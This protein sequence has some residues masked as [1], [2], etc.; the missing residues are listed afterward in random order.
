MAEETR[1]PLE[2]ANGG[3][4]GDDAPLLFRISRIPSGL[5]RS[6]RVRAKQAI[7][8]EVPNR[9]RHAFRIDLTQ[10]LLAGL[11]TGAVFPFVGVIARD[12]L[13]ATPTVL[14]LIGAAPFI[15]NLLAM[16]FAQAS[17]GRPKAPFVSWAQIISRLIILLSLFA[18]GA[19]PFALVIAGCQI[20]GT[21]ATPAY[22]AVIKDVYP[23]DQRGK[24]LGFTKASVLAAQCAGTLLAG[25]LMGGAFFFKV[26]YTHLFPI[27]GA[28]GVIAAITFGRINPHEAEQYD[29]SAPRDPV[30]KQIKAT[31]TFV[32]KTLSI[33]KED[34]AYRWFALSVFT[35][36]FGNL[37][38]VPLIP[39]IQVDELHTTS[40]QIALLSNM[41]QAAAV[42]GYFFWGRYVDR[43]SP[44]KAVIINVLLNTLIPLVYI[45]TAFMHGANAWILTPAF[46]MGGVV[47]AGIDM[48]YFNALLTFAGPRDVSRYQ[49]LQ[50]FLLGIRGTIAPFVG[51]ALAAL[52]HN[53]GQSTRWVFALSLTM[54]IIGAW[55]Q[56]VA[57][58]RQRQ[59][60]LVLDVG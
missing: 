25:A 50:S 48:S 12:K 39:L 44:Q 52:L 54:M 33:L 9:A 6:A 22:A 31:A 43:N 34:H 30:F 11:Y 24:L 46:I 5:T 19:W 42:I 23:D 60:Q 26:S 28:I 37:M 49:A 55:A 56:G 16:F 2:H 21:L 10:S 13:H 4:H 15:G 41:T 1:D 36:G 58:K 20:I 3:S 59:H 29:L 51:G 27:A 57:M 17:E 38:T 7:R 45:S 53:L 35:Y 14:A 32:G 47:G 8:K 18:V 40:P